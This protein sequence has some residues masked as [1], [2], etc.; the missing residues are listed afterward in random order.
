MPRIS[1]RAFLV[2]ILFGGAAPAVAQRGDVPSFRLDD[3]RLAEIVSA[4]NAEKESRQWGRTKV[5][6]RKLLE[7]GSPDLQ[8]LSSWWI[9]VQPGL[10]DNERIQFW[11]MA[12]QVVPKEHDW[13]GAAMAVMRLELRNAPKKQRFEIYRAAI[14]KGSV[15][16]SEGAELS[17]REACGLAAY[18]G[19]LELNDLVEKYL[20]DLPGQPSGLKATAL[21]AMEL[22]RDAENRKDALRLQVQRMAEMPRG[23]MTRRMWKQE[24][25]A[26][27]KAVLE[28]EI[29]EGN[30][31]DLKEKLT[32]ALIVPF[33]ICEEERMR[34]SG[35]D[36]AQRDS[37]CAVLVTDSAFRGE[38]VRL[39]TDEQV[40]KGALR[41][42]T[43][44]PAPQKERP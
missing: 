14:E 26:G 13:T 1:V 36:P 17:R 9:G 41:R 30:D 8:N 11:Q 22:R 4:F 6:L 24:G 28:R 19:I 2:A 10:S 40:K 25:F 38:V 21:V 42:G 32:Q 39:W 7:S 31:P 15:Q 27:A 20:Y 16:L 33:D 35:V 3:K 18:D 12:I 5:E 23:E 29:S 43:S 37:V 44:V 34:P